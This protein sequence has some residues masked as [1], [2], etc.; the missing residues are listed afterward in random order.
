M[1]QRFGQKL[2]MASHRIDEQKSIGTGWRTAQAVTRRDA[3][4]RVTTASAAQHAGA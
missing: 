3:A 2:A 1:M 4:G